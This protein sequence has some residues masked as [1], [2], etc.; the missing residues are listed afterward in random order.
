MQRAAMQIAG[1]NS[2]VAIKISTCAAAIPKGA[3]SLKGK[4]MGMGMAGR[5]A[6]GQLS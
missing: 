3:S 4:G 6:P 2:S 1:L 5:Y